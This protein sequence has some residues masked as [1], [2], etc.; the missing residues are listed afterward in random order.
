MA[1]VTEMPRRVGHRHWGV[2][3]LE[4]L[5]ALAALYG[6]IGLMWGNRIGMLDEWLVGTPFTSWTL[7]GVLL[8][9]VVA[10]PMAT[11]AV[12]EL[13]RSA[14]AGAASVAAGAA[15]IGWIAAQLVVMQRYNVQQPIML[16]CGL[17][18]VLLAVAA[19]RQGPVWPQWPGVGR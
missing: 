1:T 5:V 11:A 19:R 6:G 2:V 17:A 16:M 14:W 9:L 4:V 13:R 12:L 15:Q 7:P 3:V 8:L 18:V 10:A